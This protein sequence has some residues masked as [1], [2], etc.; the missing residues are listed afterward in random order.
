MEGSGRVHL[1]MAWHG[2]V[3]AL[4]GPQNA[5]QKV[6]GARCASS[7]AA[8]ADLQHPIVSASCHSCPSL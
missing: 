3:L 7:T 6:Q 1:G 4:R 8:I 5:A 2:Q